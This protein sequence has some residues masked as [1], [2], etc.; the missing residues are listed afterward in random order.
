MTQYIVSARKYRPTTFDS[1]VGQQ[2]LT[3]TLKNAIATG[4]LAHAYL[5]CGP[6]GVGKTTCARIFAKTINCL[7]PLENG[8]ACNH[9]ESCQAFNEG[10]SYNIH[11]LDAAS[12]NSVEDIRGLMEQVMMP[13]QVGRYKVFIIDEVHMLSTAA[14]N[15]FLKTLEEPPAH[16]IFILATTEKHKIL[17]TILSRCQI[18]DFKRMEVADI[19]AHLER[20]AQAEGI[21]Y[22]PEALGVI[23]RKADGGMRDAMSIFDQVTSYAEG[24]ITYRK[25]IEDLNVLD[26]DY[27]FKATDLLLEHNIPALLVLLDDIL[28]RGFQTGHFISGLAAHFRDL[29]VSRDAQTLPL[30]EASSAEGERYREQAAR[31]RP[32][33]LYKALRLCNQCDINHRTTS[34]KRLLVEITLIEIA[35]CE[36]DAEACGPSPTQQLKPIFNHSKT[37]TAP[38]QVQVQTPVKPAQSAHTTPQVA[39]PATPAPAPKPQLAKPVTAHRPTGIQT[40]SIRPVGT[41]KP[42]TTSTPTAPASANTSAAAPHI[43]PATEE[44]AF[45]NEDLVLEWRRFAAA[46]PEEQRATSGRMQNITPRLTNDWTVEVSVE[47]EQVVRFM[48]PFEQAILAHLQSA[49][50]NGHITLSFNVLASAPGAKVY[51]RREQLEQ[52]IARHP[53]I[54][55]LVSTFHLEFD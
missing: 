11:E 8:E 37:A 27:Y 50:H 24:N 15:A 32:S 23:A 47:N 1:V 5:F 13:P 38:A 41:A 9:C 12:N 30:L 35:Q 16:A 54:G 6:R 4:K 18:Y 34:S 46:L 2:S 43:V 29:L 31:C 28:S 26:Y 45:T 17:P 44:R 40:I 36:E 52:I 53:D 3:T 22:E 14:F 20:V 10:R 48:K 33:F 39:T 51:S 42:E 55:Q 25:V 19:V 49:L 21:S 7:T